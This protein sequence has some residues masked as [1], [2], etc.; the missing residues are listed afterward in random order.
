VRAWESGDEAGFERAVGVIR[1]LGEARA[2]Y[3]STHV[4][5][6]VGQDKYWTMGHPVAETTVINRIERFRHYA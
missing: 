4:H 6:G 3:G 1:S 2:F 5:L